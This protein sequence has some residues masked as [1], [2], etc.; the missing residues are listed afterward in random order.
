MLTLS[1]KSCTP[2]DSLSIF[3]NLLMGQFFTL[4]LR[5][6][7]VIFK[8]SACDYF[9][10]TIVNAVC[11]FPLFSCAVW[12]WL[13]PPLRLRLTP[14]KD[15]TVD[16]ALDT[17]V[18]T[19]VDT[20]VNTAVDTVV[21]MAMATAVDLAMQDMAA[22]EEDMEDTEDTAGMAGDTEATD[23]DLLASP[24]ATAAMPTPVTM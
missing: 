22:T 5:F 11:I 19:A 2:Q 3:G 1:I 20:A 16:T 17:A 13:Q 21:D 6:S 12:P 4:L 8:L 7:T 18:G 24:A 10:P 9:M 15:P 14:G 23:T